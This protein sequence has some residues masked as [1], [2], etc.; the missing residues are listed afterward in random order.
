MN[1]AQESEL[2]EGAAFDHQT[3][4]HVALDESVLRKKSFVDCVF[5]HCQLFEARFEACRFER[6]AFLHCDLSMAKVD[7]CIWLEV[8]F[9]QC[10]LMGINWT[11]I[12]DLF[13]PKIHFVQSVLTYGSFMGMNLK[14][15]RFS[16]CKVNEV[17][18]CEADLSGVAF[19]QTDLAG[20]DFLHTNLTRADFRSAKN[21]AL[22]LVDNR[23][24]GAKFAFPE[25]VSLLKS[26]GVEVDF[27]AGQ[28]E[29]QEQ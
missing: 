18:F 29:R 27:Q 28:E 9:E 22:N 15:I 19:E 2:L 21:Y 25:A 23:V 16:N 20:S 5:E 12:K 4:S 17:N 7:A 8:A 26:F 24:E 10:K 13:V 3:F 6:C 11:H 14:A 1:Y